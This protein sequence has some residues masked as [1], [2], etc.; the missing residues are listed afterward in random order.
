MCSGFNNLVS[1]F[2]ALFIAP[3][4]YKS[5]NYF[6][7]LYAL[8]HDSTVLIAEKPVLLNMYTCVSV[9]L[10]LPLLSFKMI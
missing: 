2:V 9:C 8:A 4:M 3:V 7:N 5:L 6:F 10:F 1:G